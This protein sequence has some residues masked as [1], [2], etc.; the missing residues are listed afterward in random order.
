MK[1][2]ELGSGIQIGILIIMAIGLGFTIGINS[3]SEKIK[4]L[5]TRLETFDFAKKSDLNGLLKSLQRAS[6]QLKDNLILSEENQK[7]KNEL[8][9]TND[10]NKKLEVENKTINDK[11]KYLNAL[12][13]EKFGDTG[14]FRLRSATTKRLFGNKVII[15]WKYES[16]ISGIDLTV[17]NISRNLNVGEF[18]ECDVN[19]DKYK[20]ILD[21]LDKE[22]NEAIFIYSK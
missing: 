18:T 15:T 16:F 14:K 21:S 5:E 8:V 3:Q 13:K 10:Q 6:N 1:K 9:L 19:G 11:L 17:N 20:L 22:T 7:L 4:T 2:I 12:V